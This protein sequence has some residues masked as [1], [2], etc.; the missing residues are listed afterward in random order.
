MAKPPPPGYER[1]S[2]D[3][4]LIRKLPPRS[5][6]RD[7]YPYLRSDEERR[8]QEQEAENERKAKET[9]K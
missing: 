6:A 9:R 2:L 5:A 1:H 8:Q 7:F 4:N 3:P